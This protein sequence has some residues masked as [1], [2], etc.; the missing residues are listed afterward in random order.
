M[1]HLECWD[2]RMSQRFATRSA[3]HQ[4]CKGFTLI[5]LLVVIAVIMILAALVSPAIMLAL[6]QAGRTHCASNLRQW[7]QTLSLYESHHKLELPPPINVAAYM[8]IFHGDA[9]YRISEIL[10]HNYHVS[11]DVWYCPVDEPWGGD[12]YEW[13]PANHYYGS[14]TSY[15]YLGGAAVATRTYLAGAVQFRRRSRLGSISET[16]L[17]ADM[18]RFYSGTPNVASH[19]AGHSGTQSTIGLSAQ[20]I[21]GGNRLF[22]DGHATW[23]QWKD[24]EL[25]AIGGG[26]EFYW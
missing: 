11:R 2:V 13:N 1:R 20:G 18:I 16:V 14:A 5:E 23:G 26:Y 24:M 21:E 6:R 22:A 19:C 12:D 25:H 10:I 4:R 9:N 7:G 3:R 17:M 8:N 15:V